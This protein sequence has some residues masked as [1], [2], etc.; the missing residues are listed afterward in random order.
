M[1]NNQS[2]LILFSVLQL[3]IHKFPAWQYK[4]VGGRPHELRGHRNELPH[5]KC[6]WKT[7]NKGQHKNMSRPLK[8]P[9]CSLNTNNPTCFWNLCYID[10][11]NQNLNGTLLHI[12]G[13]RLC[14][15]MS[16]SEHFLSP[17]SLPRKSKSRSNQRKM[18]TTFQESSPC[19]KEYWQPVFMIA[20]I[21]VCFFFRWRHVRSLNVRSA[22]TL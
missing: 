21:C 5:H 12:D 17:R 19:S 8:H 2:C 1:K 16:K 6:H 10:C 7:S 3:F 18:C 9:S 4:A 11:M 14:F 13:I 20:V 15:I 22:G